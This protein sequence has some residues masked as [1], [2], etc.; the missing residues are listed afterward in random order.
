MSSKRPEGRGASATALRTRGQFARLI[1]LECLCS[2]LVLLMGSYPLL[3]QVSPASQALALGS[4]LRVTEDSAR[5]TRFVG[6]L[7]AQ[8]AD[9][10]RLQ[11]EEASPDRL[12]LR[13][14]VV[15]L[16]VS[17]GRHSRWRLGAA[18]GALA[19]TAVGF[20]AIQGKNYEVGDNTPTTIYVAS[21]AVGGVLG[22]V[23]G[24]SIHT[25][26]WEVIAWPEASRSTPRAGPSA[27]RDSQRQARSSRSR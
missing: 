16:E 21:V 18:L 11:T 24:S 12:V 25:D 4:R 27:H 10:L 23:I 26:H 9:S 14:Q 1:A 5:P 20:L 3:A 22:A 15:Q 7:L 19:G 17:R 13:S 6:V 8:R 2:G